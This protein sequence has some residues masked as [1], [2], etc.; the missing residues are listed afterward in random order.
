MSTASRQQRLKHWAREIAIALSVFAAVYLVAG[1]LQKAQQRGGGGLLPVGSLAPAFRLTEVT[2]RETLDLQAL[3]GKPV[4]LKFW[5]TWCGVCRDEMPAIER[6]AA[7]AAGRF[8]LV[9]IAQD[10]PAKLARFIAQRQIGF[11]VLLD[12]SGRVHRA[13][14]VDSLPTTVIIDAEGRIVH[15]FVGAADEDVLVDHMDK[16]L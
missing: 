12:A 8:H 1:E 14:R 6:V 3:R 15:D 11:P 7:E 4:I 5:A 10:A 9:S 16:L 13:Y 2:T